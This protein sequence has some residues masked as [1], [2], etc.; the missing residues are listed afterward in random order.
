MPSHVPDVIMRRN[1]RVKRIMT[2]L[3]GPAEAISMSHGDG[4]RISD[5]AQFGHD[6]LYGD[7]NKCAIR[8]QSFTTSYPSFDQIFHNLVNSNSLLFENGLKKCFIDITYRP[9]RT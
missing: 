5:G 1:N 9:S 3:P 6:P 7:D 8:Q 2:R 4:G